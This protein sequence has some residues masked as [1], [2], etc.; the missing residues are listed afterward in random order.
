MN[1]IRD[2][3]TLRIDI[4]GEEYYKPLTLPIL[5]EDVENQIIEV[6]YPDKTRLYFKKLAFS[7]KIYYLDTFV[8][9]FDEEPLV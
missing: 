4:Y 5:D 6:E 1:A 3:N 9:P 8:R 2:E 7:T